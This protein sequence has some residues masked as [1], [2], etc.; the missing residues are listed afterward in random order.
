MAFT[1]KKLTTTKRDSID[2]D[3]ATVK[4]KGFSWEL[5]QIS[6]IRKYVFSPESGQESRDRALGVQGDDVPHVEEARRPDDLPHGVTA[7][8]HDGS[9]AKLTL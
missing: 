2:K 3:K 5:I 4:G 8:G 7:A 1:F 6:T 9:M